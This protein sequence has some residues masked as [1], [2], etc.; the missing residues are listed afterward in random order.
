MEPKL[1]YIDRFFYTIDYDAYKTEWAASTYGIIVTKE[2]YYA[3]RN[4][5]PE[6]F[7]S[8]LRSKNVIGIVMLLNY[9]RYRVK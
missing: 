2:E 1:V 5:K 4:C 3:I 8:N 7:K 9:L 6:Q